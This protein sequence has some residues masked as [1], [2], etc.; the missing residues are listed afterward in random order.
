MDTR[1][2]TVRS[3]PSPTKYSPALFGIIST[4]GMDAETVSWRGSTPSTVRL[5]SVLADCAMNPDDKTDGP[6]SC[7][8]AELRGREPS[9]STREQ[10][11]SSLRCNVSR[12]PDAKIRN[13]LSPQL[14]RWTA[15]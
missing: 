4:K 15:S 10:S 12:N 11:A 14:F 13:L 6:R 8:H 9:S 1:L 7:H 2:S 3:A 5:R